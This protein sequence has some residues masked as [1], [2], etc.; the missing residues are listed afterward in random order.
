MTDKITF[1]LDGKTVEA[2]PDE[3]IWQVAQRHGTKIPH[4][5]WHP[6]PGYRADGNCRACM[7]EVEGERVLA[8][9]C[10]RKPANGMKVKTA[11]ERAKKSRQMVF[12]LLMADQ[13]VREES[14]DPA[15]KFWNW[16]D[17]MGIEA[18][19]R[20]PR[21]ARPAPDSTHAAIAV[22]LDACISCGLCVR[23]C[24]EVQANDVIGMAYRGHESKVVFD[25]DKGMG[26]STC[27]ACGEC[28]QV[29]P[30]GALMEK[31]LLDD[32]GKRVHFE[33][34]SVDTVCPYCGVGCQTTVHVKDN[35]VLYVDGR[36]GPA[37]ENRLCVKGRFGFDY[38]HHPDRLTK[39]L[40][41]REGVPK[42]ANL[43]IRRD[44][45]HKYFREATW[46]EALTKAAAGLKAIRDRDG[47]DALA[48]FG[49]AKGSN[50]EAYLF[51]KLVRQGFGTNNVDHCTRLCHASSVAA[52]MEGVNSGAVTA[53]FTAA[54]DADCMIVIGARPAENHPVA[55]TFIKN[56]AKRG[57]KLIVMDPRGQSQG[58]ARYAY[59]TLQFK[60]GRDVALL[61]G[62]LNVIIHEGLTD[63]QYIQAHTEG[64][65]ALKEKTKE[66][67]PEAMEPVCGIP[68]A[69]IREVAHLYARSERSIIFWG[70]GVSQHTH[71]TDNA[72]C[73]IA[74]ALVTGHVGRPGT[75]LHP[76]RG[77]NNVQG[78]SDA[79]LIPMVFPDYKS[80]E[81]PEIRGKYEAFWGVQLP[82]SKG[83][84]VVE[85]MHAIKDDVIKGM[86]VMGENPAMSDP[87]VQ[88]ARE[89]LAHLEHL[90]VQ[91]IFLTETAWH[92]DV[93]L[94]ASAH[95][96][97][98]GSYSNT[99]RQVQ[100][101]RPVLNPP[102]E[103]RQDW[104]LI[105][106]IAQR[107]GVNWSYKHVSEVFTEMAYVMP[108]L[109]NI[110][111]ERLE[112]EDSVTYPCD[113][114]DKPGNEIIF[115]QSFPTKSGRAKMVPTEL[116][117]PDELPDA[118]YPWV[119][120]TGRMLEHWHTG[121]M[122]RRASNLDYLEP[123]A[124]VGVNP[125]ELDRLGVEPGSFIKVSTRRGEVTLRARADRDVAEGMVFIPFCFAEAAANLLTNPQL[126]PLGKIPEFKFCAA[127]VEPVREGALEAA[128]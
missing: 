92:A 56:A 75:G 6:A 111:W 107:I 50:E 120:T 105:Q 66:F 95:A 16:V 27:V 55:A 89:A 21:D 59:R 69:T 96:E 33:E 8:A 118:E 23:A 82:P 81:D 68:A 49:S 17:A 78:A 110:T 13:P 58:L 86:Y 88:H 83:L 48:G 54:K 108:S 3:T 127:R 93:I 77:Q 45:V 41:R 64:F 36:D 61:N 115:A 101:G 87:D 119:L 72:R 84:T 52:L 123:E 74:L 125:Q 57:A 43:Q 40:I 117:P 46:E 102:G 51:Q 71:G 62:M 2:A 80:V 29:C 60:P 65:E 79:G 34:K 114:P 15:S 30:T 25:F 26:T 18:S 126:D 70:M 99:N 112:R 42:D 22:N 14:H 109:E 11:S 37:N 12:E 5:C 113:A 44:E 76:L 94:P 39:P 35:K 116:R 122:T 106:E 24:R 91:D 73:L 20:F 63:V 47:G 98:L 85:I 10:Q 124:I 97:K 9:S 128:E 103:A 53:P 67:T 90:V 28:V 38:I 7:V 1:E 32:K 19:S 100:I 121:S 4:L 31:S 104:E